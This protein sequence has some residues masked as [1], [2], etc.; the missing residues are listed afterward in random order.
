MGIPKFYGRWI[1]SDKYV[2]VIIW[3]LPITIANFMIDG[4]G[5]IHNV[6]QDHYGYG[7]GFNARIAAAMEVADPLQQEYEFH[8][9]FGKYLLDL[10]MK[11]K[12]QVGFILAIDG[13]API[14]KISQQQERR[15]KAVHG[16]NG[17]PKRGF[18]S[19]CI[20]PGT[21]F[22][23][24]LDQNIQQ[25]DIYQQRCSSSSTYLFVTYGSRGR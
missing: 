15:N 6:A 10:I 9:K 23:V 21:P 12:P 25:M 16:L 5:S 2:G 22:M 24:L 19:N 13:V 3:T 20:T 4:N 1:T 14:G 18:D 17:A 8:K 7:K 11:I